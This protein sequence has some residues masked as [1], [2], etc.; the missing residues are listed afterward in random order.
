[1][2]HFDVE[3]IEL[4]PYNR[5][6]G[7]N[8]FFVFVDVLSLTL[9]FLLQVQIHLAMKATRNLNQ[10]LSSRESSGVQEQ[11]S[12][13]NSSK[14]SN[15]HLAEP[16]TQTYTQERN[17]LKKQNYKKPEFK[18]GSQIGGQGS[19][20]NSIHNNSTRSIPCRYNLL[21]LHNSITLTEFSINHPG[22]SKRTLQLLLEHRRPWQ[23]P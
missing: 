21:S 7:S 17:S 18:F 23:V 22:P 9:M 12:L 1:M 16:N 5:F 6:N 2:E 14:P 8:F 20:N 10:E 11:P 13:A 15:E 3:F 4:L 19:E